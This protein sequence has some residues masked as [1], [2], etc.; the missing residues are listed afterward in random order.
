MKG[1]FL[2]LDGI[3]GCGKSTQSRL[4]SDWLRSRGHA[5]TICADPGGT[6]LG[7]QLRSIL[8]QQK[9]AL[10]LPAEALLFMASRAQLVADVIRPALERGDDVVSD[11]FLLANVV[12]QGYGGGLDPRQ[13][14]EA[15]RLSTGG[16]QP[17]LTFVLDL[18][19]ALARTRRNRPPDSME[20]RDDAYH[21]RVRDGFLTEARKKPDTIIVLDAAQPVEVVQE[22]IV[23]EVQRVL[24]ARPG[25]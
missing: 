24:E 13:L 10:A 20:G 2:S 7:D 17:D 3:D 12:Y 18:P 15:G 1:L 11:R 21:Q 19:V 6:P 22:R 25:A 23:Q 8:L 4:L 9:Q 5:V 14:W 16:L